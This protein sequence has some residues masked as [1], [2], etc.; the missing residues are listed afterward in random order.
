MIVRDVLACCSCRGVSFR[1]SAARF[2]KQF[3]CWKL[4]DGRLSSADV[5]WL[6]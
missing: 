3:V 1:A 2:S 4:S 6:A 5:K